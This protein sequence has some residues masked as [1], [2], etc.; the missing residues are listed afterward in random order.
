MN[1]QATLTLFIFLLLL[2]K[3]FAQTDSLSSK[4]LSIGSKQTGIC[5]GNSPIYT[6]IRFNLIDKQVKRVNIIN[7]SLLKAKVDKSNGLSLGLFINEDNYNNGL[8]LASIFNYG[9]SR[10]GLS[11]GG[12]FLNAKKINGVGFAGMSVSGDTLNG[13]FLGL[14]GVTSWSPDW[15]IKSI[16]GCAMGLVGT[17]AEKVNGLTVGAINGS[18]EHHGLSVGLFNRTEKLRG[19]QI[20]LINYAGN[21]PKGL[22]WLPLINMHLG[23]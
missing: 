3:V 2:G 17:G 9:Q 21:N 14:Y 10:N 1:K 18:N 20:G 4:Y 11:I 19:V 13:L 6:G 22:R 8:S 23:K 16:N 7:F 12:L 15:K 5:F